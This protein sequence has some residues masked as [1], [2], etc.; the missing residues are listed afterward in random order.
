MSKGI[1]MSN[2]NKQ[3]K[4]RLNLPNPLQ[5]PEIDANHQIWFLKVSGTITGDGFQ[6]ATT[7]EHIVGIFIGR[8][9]LVEYVQKKWGIIPGDDWEWYKQRLHYIFGLTLE[10]HYGFDSSIPFETVDKYVGGDYNRSRP[11]VT[12]CELDQMLDGRHIE[13]IRGHTKT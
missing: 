11:T 13:E 9:A 8:D 7:V 3:D 6:R 12:Q 5:E 10:Q 2:Q 1:A 4:I